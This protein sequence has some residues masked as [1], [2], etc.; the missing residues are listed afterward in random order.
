MIVYGFDSIALLLEDDWYLFKLLANDSGI[1]LFPH[2]TEHRD[3]TQPGIQYLDN[4]LGNAL[5]AM[6][7]PG[8]IEFRHHRKFSDDRVK[9]LAQR[10]L[11]VPAM[12]FASDATVTY[13]GRTLI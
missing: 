8:R 3:A 5:A 4:S 2:T 7:K 6:V 12:E 9:Q 11:V 13:Q 1:V 10:M